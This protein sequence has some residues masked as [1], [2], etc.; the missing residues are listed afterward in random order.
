VAAS[1]LPLEAVQRLR[2]VVA[3]ADMHKKKP[4][5]VTLPPEGQT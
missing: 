2:Q 4:L 3:Q 1:G 5:R